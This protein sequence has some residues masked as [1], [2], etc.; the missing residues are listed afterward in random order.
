MRLRRFL[1]LLAT[2]LAAAPLAAQAETDAVAGVPRCADLGLARVVVMLPP[3]KTVEE[4]TPSLQ[5]GGLLP[6]GGQATIIPAGQLT[7][8]TNR[9]EFQRR[10]NTTLNLFLE[11][12][13]II[14]GSLSILLRVDEEGEVREV[15]PHSGNAEVNRLLA[16]TWRQA[17]FQPYQVDGCRATAWLQV[18]Q[19]F[20]SDWSPTQRSVR[21]SGEPLQPA[22]KG[23]R[24]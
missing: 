3:G 12:G 24:P 5:S 9:E 19:N 15:H 14:D 2:L 21:V 10:L 13:I 8:I 18:P 20:R 4:I 16:R 1:P 7:P 22:P 17:R 6:A 11:Q 23:A